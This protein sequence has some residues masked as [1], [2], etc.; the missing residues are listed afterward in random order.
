MGKARLENKYSRAR[1]MKI[2]NK[3]MWYG[4]WA[5]LINYMIVTNKTIEIKEINYNYTINVLVSFC[6]NFLYLC[7]YLIH[8]SFMWDVVYIPNKQFSV[9]K[10]LIE[11]MDIISWL[12]RSLI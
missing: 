6:I 12:G 1:V 8:V 4:K 9:S 2:R 7:L 5:I 10:I 3:E 11:I